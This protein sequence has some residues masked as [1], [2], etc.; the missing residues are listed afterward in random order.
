MVEKI[1]SNYGEKICEYEDISYYNFPDVETLSDAPEVEAKLRKLGFGY[2]AKY[3]DKSAKE[4]VAKGG[5]K[6][7]QEVEKMDYKAAHAELVTLTGIG[8]KVAD[9]IA[10]MSLN[11]LQS[12]PVDTHI[13]QIA[14]IY[15]PHLDIKK[16]LTPKTYNEIGDKFRSIYGD[17]AGWAQTVLFCSDLRQFQK[18]KQPDDPKPNKKMKKVN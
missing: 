5:L 7:F 13:L 9:C 10:L 11:F 16:S 15:M 6:W 1:C 2:R 17:M 4:I 14:K 18:N 8:P 3:I 12:I